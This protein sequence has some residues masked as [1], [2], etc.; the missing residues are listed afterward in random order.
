MGFPTRACME[1]TS[2]DMKQSLRLVKDVSLSMSW[3][4]ESLPTERRGELLEFE[5]KKMLSD[6]V[7]F[8]CWEIIITN[9]HFEKWLLCV[10]TIVR[11]VL[12]DI[13]KAHFLLPSLGQLWSAR[14]HVNRGHPPKGSG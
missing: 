6:S 8:K 3:N 14:E 4:A 1:L 5:K 7:L 2:V 10:I 9:S 12:V 13:I 11:T